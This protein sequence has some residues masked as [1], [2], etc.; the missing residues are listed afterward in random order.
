MSLVRLYETTDQ[1]T[2]NLIKLRFDEEGIVY[3]VFF[4]E[5]LRT[6]SAEVLGNRG[7]IIEVGESYFD[8]SKDLLRELDIDLDYDNKEDEFAFLRPFD[9]FTQKI[10]LLG[11]IDL[12][13]RLIAIAFLFVILLFL[14]VLI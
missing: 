8:I 12:P 13:F 5:M 4:E 1:M 6:G 2:L 11:Q 9:E 10:P 7:A 3:R 14:A